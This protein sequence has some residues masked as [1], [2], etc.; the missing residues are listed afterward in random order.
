MSSNILVDTR[1]S[2]Q[3]YCI[4]VVKSKVFGLERGTTRKPKTPKTYYIEEP[5]V[6][7]ILKIFKYPRESCQASVRKCGLCVLLLSYWKTTNIK[8]VCNTFR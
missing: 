6:T 7:R 2:E 5:G 8:A 1:A 4:H 3:V